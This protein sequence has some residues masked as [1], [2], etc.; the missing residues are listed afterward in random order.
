MKRNFVVNVSLLSFFTQKKSTSKDPNQ[1][2][3]TSKTE[4]ANIMPTLTPQHR[5]DEVTRA[6]TKDGLISG[7][8]ALIPAGG[9]LFLA[10]K[11]PTFLKV[12]YLLCLCTVSVLLAFSNKI[13][14]Q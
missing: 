8:L 4:S 1:A 12:C 3:Q 10:M 9:A 11:N 13:P 14:S 6:A 5:S 2:Q 7:G